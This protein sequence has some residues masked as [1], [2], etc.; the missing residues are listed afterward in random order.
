MMSD[1][2]VPFS[3]SSPDV[4]ATDTSILSKSVDDHVV[5]SAKTTCSTPCPIA[6]P[7][8]PLRTTEP[9]SVAPEAL[10]AITSV[11]SSPFRSRETRETAILVNTSLSTDP[12]DAVLSVMTSLPS[13]L[14]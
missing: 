1:A 9:P 14:L 7:T 6:P 4:P 11:T 5:P 10:G 8:S 3:V 12:P 2:L 13:P